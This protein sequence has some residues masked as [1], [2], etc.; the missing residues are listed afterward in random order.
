MCV[1]VV[2]G[3]FGFSFDCRLQSFLFSFAVGF[4][5]FYGLYGNPF[6]DISPASG[7][8]ILTLSPGGA[9]AKIGTGF[10]AILMVTVNEVRISELLCYSFRKCFN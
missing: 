3:V 7:S 6:L 1:V 10:I 5:Y 4:C 2:V 9:N 8:E